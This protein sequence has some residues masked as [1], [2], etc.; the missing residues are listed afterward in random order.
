MFI[1]KRCK[2]V[3]LVK[4]NMVQGLDFTE[5]NGKVVNAVMPEEEKQVAN[6]FTT[7]RFSSK[8]NS[9]HGILFTVWWTRSLD[10]VQKMF[11]STS[12]CW[13]VLSGQKWL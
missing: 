12:P 4:D 5:T 8:K 6:L 1:C 9:R 13:D 11:A 7:S 2:E 3:P 10:R